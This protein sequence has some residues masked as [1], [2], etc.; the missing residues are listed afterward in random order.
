MGKENIIV[1]LDSDF[2]CHVEPAEGRMEYET[3]F[4]S[5]REELIEYYRIIPAGYSWTNKNGDVFAGEMITPIK[6]LPRTGE[7]S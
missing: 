5:G 2:C 4:F 6:A 1:Y 7:E 3:D